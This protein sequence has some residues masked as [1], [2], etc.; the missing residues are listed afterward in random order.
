MSDQSEITSRLQEIWGKLRA[1]WPG[2]DA[3]LFHQQYIVKMAETAEYLETVCAQL[4]AGADALAKKL[5]Q[6]EHDI[7]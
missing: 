6:I 3:N 5:D 1:R 4:K 2:E 7:S